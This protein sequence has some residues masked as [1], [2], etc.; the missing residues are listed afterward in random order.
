MH[1]REREQVI[2]KKKKKRSNS[3]V[4]KAKEIVQADGGRRVTGEMG[5]MKGN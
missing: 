3:R 5:A 4:K 1:G 2:T